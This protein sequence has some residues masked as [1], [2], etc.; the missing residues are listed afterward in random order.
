MVTTGRMSMCEQNQVSAAMIITATPE[1][2]FRVVGS[3]YLR[4]QS[5]FSDYNDAVEQAALLMAD[6]FDQVT[7]VNLTNEAFN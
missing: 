5:V 2:G 7:I 1:T 4:S 3:R 6:G